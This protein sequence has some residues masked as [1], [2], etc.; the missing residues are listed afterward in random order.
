MKINCENCLKT[1]VIDLVYNNPKVLNVHCDC[2]YQNIIEIIDFIKKYSNQLINNS[3]KDENTNEGFHY[4]CLL[5][6]SKI[7]NSDFAIHSN[8]KK[9]NLDEYFNKSK[10]IL[11]KSK[12]D[13]IK[14]YLLGYYTKLKDEFISKLE[15]EI[16]QINICFNQNYFINLNL[17]KTIKIL[18]TS[19]KNNKKD[20]Q[21]L[22]NL[23]RNSNHSTP[24]FIYKDQQNSLYEN[25]E[26]LKHFYHSTFI[27]FPKESPTIIQLN[28]IQLIHT[29]QSH[30]DRITKLILLKDGRLAS[31][32]FDY[33][34]KIFNLTTFKYQ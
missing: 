15:K 3:D 22:N 4:Y 25:I 19:C 5:C 6:K 21:T 9:I 31:S 32:S 10:Q 20:Y 27:F 7:N 28:K 8:H 12:L 14:G 23:F 17:L 2:G 26:K 29:N 1:P 18:F 16:N 34:I 24:L 13:E 33:S 11:F 30:T